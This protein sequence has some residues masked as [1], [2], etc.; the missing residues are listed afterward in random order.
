MIEAETRTEIETRI[1]ELL[2]WESMVAYFT[3]DLNLTIQIIEQ[4]GWR[5]EIKWQCED[6]YEVKIYELSSG[7]KIEQAGADGI[8]FALA[9]AFLA[10]LEAQNKGE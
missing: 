5:P 9:L 6:Y 7:L 2:G 10:A 4:M 1:A 3:T 8:C